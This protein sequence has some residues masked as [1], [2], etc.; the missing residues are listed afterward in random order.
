MLHIRLILISFFSGP[1]YIRPNQSYLY[2]EERQQK[3]IQKE[4]DNI[5]DTV[6]SHL[7]HI[8]HMP[9][10]ATI[11]GRFSEQLATYL[12]NEHMAPI[13]YLNIHRARKEWKL[14]KSIQ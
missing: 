4:Y 7:V 11:I 3:Q 8:H 10:T 13:S 5:M 14:V 2:K 1:N 9:P 6:T 12:V